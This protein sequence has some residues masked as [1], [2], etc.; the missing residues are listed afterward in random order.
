MLRQIVRRSDCLSV[1]WH[2]E[3]GVSFDIIEDIWAFT[4]GMSFIFEGQSYKVDFLELNE[5]LTLDGKL[6]RWS[7]IAYKERNDA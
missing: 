4:S 5:K 3:E 7:V 1:K 2:G 6:V